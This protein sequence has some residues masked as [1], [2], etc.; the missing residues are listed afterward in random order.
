M[1]TAIRTK[2][3]PNMRKGITSWLFMDALSFLRCGNGSRESAGEQQLVLDQEPG[4]VLLDWDLV[5]GDDELDALHLFSLE[6]SVIGDKEIDIRAG[7]ACELNG[8]GCTQ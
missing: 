2:K 4:M 7:G 3:P 1:M 8:V 5:Q 6:T